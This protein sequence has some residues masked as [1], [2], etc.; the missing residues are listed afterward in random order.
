MALKINMTNLD[1]F[2]NKLEGLVGSK[3][4]DEVFCETASGGKEEFE[5]FFKGM[6]KK[7]GVDSPADLDDEKKKEF[8]NAIDKGFKGDKESD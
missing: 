7:F 4:A 6:L 1:V 2:Y 3:H 8:F 5:K